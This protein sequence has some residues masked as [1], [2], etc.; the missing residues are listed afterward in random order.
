M[1][2]DHARGLDTLQ[3]PYRRPC[4]TLD[5]LAD[6]IADEL[7]SLART[8]DAYHSGEGVVAELD[9]ED[10]L[11]K[12][13]ALLRA[14]HDVDFTFYRHTTIKRRIIRRMVLLKTQSVKE[15]VKYLRERPTELEVLYQ[16]ILIKV[17][18]FFRDP[19]TFDAITEMARTELAN[20]E[21]ALATRSA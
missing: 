8:R 6:Q 9:R 12:I 18:H 14:A 7:A 2:A 4:R 10:E 3:R 11:K 15:Y 20:A 21:K 1:P 17:T 19:E 5:R 16:D 13:F